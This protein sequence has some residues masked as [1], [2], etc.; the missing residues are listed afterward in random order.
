MGLPFGARFAEGR[1]VA[2]GCK[3]EV[4]EQA[5]RHATMCSSA[6]DVLRCSPTCLSR[7]GALWI[8]ANGLPNTLNMPLMPSKPAMLG[9]EA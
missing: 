7:S 5:K 2:L 8:C 3:G 9:R 1:Q 6:F 4:P